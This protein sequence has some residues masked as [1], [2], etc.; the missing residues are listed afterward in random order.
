[1]VHVWVP[2]GHWAVP[3]RSTLGDVLRLVP[4]TQLFPS[5]EVPL[6]SQNDR[7]FRRKT[8]SFWVPPLLEIAI[9]TEGVPIDGHKA[10][11]GEADSFAAPDGS[12]D[13]WSTSKIIIQGVVISPSPVS[14][15]TWIHP[16]YKRKA[17]SKLWIQYVFFLVSMMSFMELRGEDH[18]MYSCGSFHPGGYCIMTL[19]DHERNI[20]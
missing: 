7:I 14:L 16:F 12:M 2:L 15:S 19:R 18:F 20:S 6:R 13:P 10:S 17:P 11:A 3:G 1:M 5:M 4:W 8:H 9:W